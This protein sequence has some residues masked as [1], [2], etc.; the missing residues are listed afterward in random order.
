M[1]EKTYSDDSFGM[2]ISSNIPLCSLKSLKYSS[3]SSARYSSAASSTVKRRKIYYISE[4]VSGY[5]KFIQVQQ[6]DRSG[7]NGAYARLCRFSPRFPLLFWLLGWAY[8]ILQR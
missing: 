7:I 8:P 6:T 2:R 4:Y 3:S 1:G 5:L